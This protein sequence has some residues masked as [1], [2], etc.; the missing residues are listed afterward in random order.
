MIVILNNGT[1][2]KIEKE[3]VQDIFK[4]LAKFPNS[5]ESWH[6]QIGIDGKLIGF[7]LLQVSAICQEDDV[8]PEPVTTLKEI[9][10][11]LD[12]LPVHDAHGRF[13]AEKFRRFVLDKKTSI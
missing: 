4:N 12:T 11:F 3:M 9:G 13:W 2:I 5:R 10:L 6:C 1:R 8:L 7:N